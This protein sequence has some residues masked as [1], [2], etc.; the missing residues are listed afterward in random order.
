MAADAEAALADAARRGTAR[1]VRAASAL[2]RSTPGGDIDR[3]F[4]LGDVTPLHLAAWRGDARVVRALCDAGASLTA[5]DGESGWSPL[6]RAFHHGN[7]RA[8]AALLARGASLHA[9]LDRLGR[10]PLDVLTRALRRRFDDDAEAE[11]AAS[12]FSSAR[13]L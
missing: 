12:T 9:P 8:A 6:H 7:A 2:V 3:R 4:G 5:R 11:A 1:Q 10:S 13:A